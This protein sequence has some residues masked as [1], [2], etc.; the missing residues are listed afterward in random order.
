M[1]SYRATLDVPASTVRTISAWLAAH[2]RAH[3]IRPAQRAATSWAQAVL[4][5][6]WLIEATDLKTLARDSGISLATAYRYLHEALEVIAQRA[7]SLSQVLEQM[8]QQGEPFLCL[9]GTLIHASALHAREPGR[10]TDAWFSGKHQAFGGNVQVLTDHTGYPVWISPVEPGS[11]HDITAARRH[12][13]PA[14]YKAAA[15]G[16]PTLADKGYTGAGIGIKVPVKAGPKPDG[17][18]RWRNYL[19]TSLRAPA[20]RANAL[21]KSFKA[22]RYVTISPHR[23]TTITTA[24]LVILTLHQPSR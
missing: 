12:V 5:L 24:A 23:I 13:L 4:V 9:D 6:R 20:E 11:T 3:D 14:L 1:L 18:T 21:L 7:P 19:I 17:D 10:T 22:L 15:Q 16:L 8:R 2:R